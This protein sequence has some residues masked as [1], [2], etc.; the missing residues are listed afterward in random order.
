MTSIPAGSR[1]AAE[2][3]SGAP[4]VCF[5]HWGV[6]ASPTMHS[7]GAG[8]DTIFLVATFTPVCNHSRRVR[9]FECARVSDTFG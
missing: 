7:T 1:A 4:R 8:A 9:E 5:P 3:F 2:R 6:L